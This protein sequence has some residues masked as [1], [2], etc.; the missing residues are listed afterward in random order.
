MRLDVMSKNLTKRT[1]SAFSVLSLAVSIAFFVYAYNRHLFTSLEALQAYIAG[2]GAIGAL[3]FIA[4]QAVQVVVPILPGGL[5]CLGGVLLFGPWTGLL[6]NYIGICIGSITAFCIARNCGKPILYSI[7][8]E[9]T[10]AKYETWTG[11][12]SQFAKWFA[13]AIFLPVAP[14]DFLCYLAGTTQMSWKNFV[15]VILL[16]KPANIALYTLGLNT[17]FHQIVSLMH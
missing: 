9:K 10:I 12:A 13:I 14:D 3:V 16:G 1:I 8:N 2:F 11:N 6:Y 17:V 15:A 4:F 5:G 7:F